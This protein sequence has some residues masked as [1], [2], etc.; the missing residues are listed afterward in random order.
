M[1]EPFVAIQLDQ[2]RRAY[3]GG[4]TLAGRYSIEPGASQQVAAV[5]VSILWYTE[6]KGS[7]DFGVHYFD[8][9]PAAAE[10]APAGRSGGR[11][12]SVLPNS[13]LSYDGVIVKI[14]WCVRVRVFLA[15]DRQIVDEQPFQMGDIPTARNLSP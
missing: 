9:Q 6:G 12:E 8:R 3:R 7:E 4:D 14:H 11:F 10:N 15:S 1:T 13:P 5:E 2:S